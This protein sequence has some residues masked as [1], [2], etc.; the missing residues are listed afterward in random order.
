M[1]RV[2]Y[3]SEHIGFY[4]VGK[5]RLNSEAC[6]AQDVHS[7]CVILPDTYK[8]GTMDLDEDFWTPLPKSVLKLL[9]PAKGTAAYALPPE[10]RLQKVVAE[11]K[12]ALGGNEAPSWVVISLLRPGSDW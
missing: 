4:R 8:P 5:M 3:E 2:P 9:H 12:S 7:K 6:T 11:Y 10:E 1:F